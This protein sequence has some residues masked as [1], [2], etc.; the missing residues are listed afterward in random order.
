MK[1]ISEKD[2]HKEL[3]TAL[4]FDLRDNPKTLNMINMLA[5]K[6]GE[7][8]RS[9]FIALLKE[10]VENAYRKDSRPPLFPW[11]RSA[12]QTAISGGINYEL[13]GL[14]QWGAVI[15]GAIQ[16]LA[17]VGSSIYSAKLASSTQLKIAKMNTDS[18]NQQAAAAQAAANAQSLAITNAAVANVTG[19]PTPG[20]QMQ[21]INT[22]NGPIQVPVQESS[23]L[24][25]MS[26]GLLLVAAIGV[27][28]F[29]LFKHLRG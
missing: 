6:H 13:L 4:L 15:G 9:T 8:G 1:Q 2:L 18:A 24:G 12:I 3:E 27:G 11:T 5:A 7:D 23:M 17:A 21:T 16:A 20:T 25:G 22:P 10:D 29:F 26:G 14:G 19:S 28:G